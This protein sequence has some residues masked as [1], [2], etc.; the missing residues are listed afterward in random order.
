MAGNGIAD[1][2]G[3]KLTLE[4]RIIECFSGVPTDADLKESYSDAEDR[5]RVINRSQIAALL[6]AVFEHNSDDTAEEQ[7]EEDAEIKTR[8]L[9]HLADILR[10]FSHD[11]ARLDNGLEA[12]LVLAPVRWESIQPKQLI[13]A[14]RERL[15]RW[16][17]LIE[18]WNPA[19]DT[20][21]PTQKTL[22]KEAAD[23]LESTEGRLKTDLSKLRAAVKEYRQ[24][25]GSSQSS[26][27]ETRF[28][29]VEIEFYVDLEE[30]CRE[31]TT[32]SDEPA[33]PFALLWPALNALKK[34]PI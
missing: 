34:T 1:F 21:F 13:K 18:L 5:A 14:Q 6:T 19:R 10:S 28:S 20:E 2:L 22:L 32:T 9:T 26:P 29:T 8:A 27:M 4:E 31:L 17:V 12:K 15:L 30:Y 25:S 33:S 3:H 24:P 23:Q 7:E 16:L 11:A